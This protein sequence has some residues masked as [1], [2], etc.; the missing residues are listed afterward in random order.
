M[1]LFKT[2]SDSEVPILPLAFRSQPGADSVGLFA[3]GSLSNSAV[4][5]A[6]RLGTSDALF[7]LARECRKAK[8]WVGGCRGGL[9]MYCF[10]CITVHVWVPVRRGGEWLSHGLGS[11]LLRLAHPVRV[12]VWPALARVVLCVCVCVRAC[13]CVCV[14]HTV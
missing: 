9:R 1:S 11:N 7:S 14:C 2:D 10:L 6:Q 5:A 12:R 13:V 3:P 8:C 4:S